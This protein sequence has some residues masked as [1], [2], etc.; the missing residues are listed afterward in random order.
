MP[1]Q[2]NHS[3]LYIKLGPGGEWAPECI[4]KGIIKFGYN[5]VSHSDCSS[6]RWDRVENQLE[7][8][9]SD[10][11]TI[12]RDLNQIMAFY[13]SDKNMIWVTFHGDMLWWCKSE[14]KIMELPEGFKVR[15]TIGSW[16]C[17]D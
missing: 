9:R 16:K 4:D 14:P 5:E 10:K 12:K 6:G 11:G 15:E 3:V 1:K 2:S 8:I 13:K 7:N 17:T